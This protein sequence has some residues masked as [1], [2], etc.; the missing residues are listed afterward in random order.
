MNF[1]E[2]VLNRDAKVGKRK[3]NERWAQSA[4]RVSISSCHRATQLHG[5][6]GQK[7]PDAGENVQNVGFDSHMTKVKIFPPVVDFLCVMGTCLEF[8]MNKNMF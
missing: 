4:C 8:L 3:R 2:K 1:T 5:S 6:F 7:F